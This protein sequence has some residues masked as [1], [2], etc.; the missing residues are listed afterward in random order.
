MGHLA[1][2]LIRQIIWCEFEWRLILTRKE[3]K[4]L[5]LG[6]VLS[7]TNWYKDWEGEYWTISSR[8]WGLEPIFI[9]L[10]KMFYPSWYAFSS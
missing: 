7:F 1:M 10:D 9:N 4:L 3:H 5:S 8:D 6:N 2:F